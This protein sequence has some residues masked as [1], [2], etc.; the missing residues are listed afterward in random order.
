MVVSCVICFTCLTWHERREA[1]ENQGTTEWSLALTFSVTTDACKSSFH[2][3]TARAYLFLKSWGLKK[4]LSQC[5]SCGDNLPE[6]SI[7]PSS[8][9][10]PDVY[11]EVCSSNAGHQRNYSESLEA[12]LQLNAFVLFSVHGFVH[13]LNKN[14]TLKIRF[15]KEEIRKKHTIHEDQ[16]DYS[17]HW[18]IMSFEFLHTYFSLT[19]PLPEE[20]NCPPLRS[21]YYWGQVLKIRSWGSHF[22]AL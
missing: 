4:A 2:P 3:A 16:M 11:L 22:S 14:C 17:L 18:C 21:S 20:L 5:L 15:A 8:R 13:I 12:C 1:L 7:P 10:T 6:V 9:S 19:A